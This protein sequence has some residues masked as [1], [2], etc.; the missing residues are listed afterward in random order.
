MS[1][2]KQSSKKDKTD[3]LAER[4]KKAIKESGSGCDWWQRM[5]DTRII[6]K[7]MGETEREEMTR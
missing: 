5:R 3:G 2:K 7:E 1:G 4:I 6:P